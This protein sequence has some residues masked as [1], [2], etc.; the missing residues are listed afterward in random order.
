MFLC[1][2]HL[3]GETDQTVSKKSVGESGLSRES[4]KRIGFGNCECK[5]DNGTKLNSL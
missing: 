2:V 1:Y 5:M 3:A 4:S